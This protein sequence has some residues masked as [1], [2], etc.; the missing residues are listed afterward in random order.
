MHT[1]LGIVFLLASF[2]WGDWR[3]WKDYYPT[4]QFFI[5]GD[6]LY[7]FLLHHYLVWEYSRSFDYLWLPNHSF[8]NLFNMVI[9]YPCVVVMYISHFPF[10]SSLFKKVLYISFWVAIFTIKE[11]VNLFLFEHFSHKYG[12]NLGWSILFNFIIFSMLVLHFKFTKTALLLSSIII[13][14]L[15]LLFKVPIKGMN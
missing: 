7:N 11:M 13:A 1:L 8:I 3:N 2:R 12:W 4:I 9:I 6:L 10:N 15:W 5:I 14:V